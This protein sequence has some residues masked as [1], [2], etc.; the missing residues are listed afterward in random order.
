MKKIA[1]DSPGELCYYLYDKRINTIV[2]LTYCSRGGSLMI[3][4]SSSSTDAGEIWF[5]AKRY[6]T[7]QYCKVLE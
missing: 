7:Q 3:W 2:L 1:L 5:V 4:S 6:N